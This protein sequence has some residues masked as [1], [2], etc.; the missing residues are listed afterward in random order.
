MNRVSFR[1]LFSFFFFSFDR[2][3]VALV[4]FVFFLSVDF[5]TTLYSVILLLQLLSWERMIHII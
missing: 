5:L 3:S 1:L 4:R 2:R